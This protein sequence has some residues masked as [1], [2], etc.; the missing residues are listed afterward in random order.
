MLSHPLPI[1]ALVGHYPTNKLIG[2]RPS[3]GGI[4][5]LLRRHYPVLPA[6]SRGYPGP[7]GRY[8]RVT[9][10]F[11]AVHS[12]KSELLA[13]LACLIH[14]ANVH[15]EPGSNPS[16]S[17]LSTDEPASSQRPKQP[18]HLSKSK[19]ATNR[20]AAGSIPQNRVRVTPKR[21]P[22]SVPPQKS[23]STQVTKIFSVVDARLSCVGIPPK[24]RGTP[25][26]SARHRHCRAQRSKDSTH[27]G[28]VKRMIRDC[29]C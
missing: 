19:R 4:T 13:R 25:S 20:H 21:E 12:P 23:L 27:P 7:E 18:V 15:S 2:R 16:C 11:A 8:P 5:P 9:L 26:E 14:A 6:V 24:S 29:Q 1:V 17:V 3:P 10:P 28:T 22:H